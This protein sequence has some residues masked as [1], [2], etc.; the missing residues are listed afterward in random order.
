M[1]M[2]GRNLLLHPELTPR[3]QQFKDAN[4]VIVAIIDADLI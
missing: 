4:M 1:P 3:F 2:V